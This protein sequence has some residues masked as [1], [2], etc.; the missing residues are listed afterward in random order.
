MFEAHVH[1]DDMSDIGDSNDN[2][3]NAPTPLT[4]PLSKCKKH[5]TNQSRTLCK[6]NGAA[7]EGHC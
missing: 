4:S 2:D 7:D 5:S 3:S 6:S 1:S